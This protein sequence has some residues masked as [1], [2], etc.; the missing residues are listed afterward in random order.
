MSAQN[1]AATDAA[2]LL[3]PLRIGSVTIP[4][5]L[6]LAPMAGVT[7]QPFRILCRQL[8]A[9]LAVSE[10]ISA[11]PA[12]QQTRKSLERNDHR[13]EPGPIAVQI[14]GA[15]PEQMAEAA[16]RSVGG[17]AELIDIN[18]GC[19]AKKVC[20]VAAGSALL[21]DEPLVARIL[22]AVVRAVEVPVSLKARTGWSP[23]TRNLPR[24]A[25]IALDSGIS[26]LTVH[27]RTRACGYQGEA[28]V[29][30]LASIRERW[31]LPLVANGDIDGLSKALRVL[32]QTGADAIMIGRAALGR[33]WLFGAMAAR[34]RQIS[35]SEGSLGHAPPTSTSEL[36]FAPPAAWIGAVLMEH[37]DRLYRFYGEPRGVLIARK[38]IGWY[39]RDLDSQAD[40]IAEVERSRAALM[41]ASTADQQ[42]ALLRRL[43]E[44][45]TATELDRALAASTTI[46]GEESLDERRKRACGA[47]VSPF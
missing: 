18:L 27:G 9:G 25:D 40:A 4:N 19:P 12:L 21:R 26:L 2:T 30:T 44:R 16:R 15:V 6:I 36:S 24:I 8:G 11:N 14:A 42:Q 20:K 45:M 43:F 38:H 3:A 29:D 33:P 32:N 34:L 35:A 39:L 13:G 47:R 17:G 31:P 28:E 7:D 46:D 22:E 41:A 37:L 5:R 23:Q 10:M 1:T